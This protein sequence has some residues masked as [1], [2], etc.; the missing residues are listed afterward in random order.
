MRISA[1]T[2][3]GHHG[4]PD[5]SI[6]SLAPGLNVFYGPAGTGKTALADLVSHAL[7]GRTPKWGLH[8]D[9]VVLPEGQV[10]VET[11]GTRYRLRRYRNGTTDGRLTV[12]SLDGTQVHSEAVREL[13]HGLSPS[14]A[15][16]LY[17]MS[18]R[19]PPGLEAMLS[20]DFVRR[21]LAVERGQSN[22]RSA[23][24]AELLARREALAHDL[25]SRISDGRRASRTL[26]D[27]WGDLDRQ[28]HQ[29]EQ[30]IAKAR[31]QLRA[32][33]TAL[34]ET[35][36]RLRY[37]RLETSIDQLWLGQRSDCESLVAELDV[38]IAHWR[39]LLTDLSERQTRMR[40]QIAQI[41]PGDAAT[42]V[43]D[44][45]AWLSVARQLTTDL[46]GEVSRLARASTSRE[47]V[48][49]DA[50]PRLRPIVETLN[51][52]LN[53]LAALVD[54]HERAAEAGDLAREVEH[55]DRTEV[56]VRRQLDH[57]LDRRER[58]VRSGRPGLVSTSD[59]EVSDDSYITAADAELLEVRRSELEHQRY[60]LCGQIADLELDLAALCRQRDTI[61]RQ[62]ATLLSAGEID[63]LQ[64]ELASVERQLATLTTL[65]PDRFA[66]TEGIAT[67]LNRVSD[68]LAQLTG[69][70]LI[71]AELSVDGSAAHVVNRAGERLPWSVLAPARKDQ[72]Y[73]SLCLAL[74]SACEG[75]GVR[76]PLVLDEPFLRLDQ[77]DTAALAAVLDE[78][79]RCGS[80]ALVFTSQRAVAQRFNALGMHVHDMRDLRS[81]LSAA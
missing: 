31:D 46:E 49:G 55:L 80:Q 42:T 3:D 13:L 68:F 8:A 21:L 30:E 40:S 75:Q 26:R 5:L 16:R 43:A 69:G 4:R 63:Q 81:G 38:Q 79:A 27:Q 33:D 39:D 70:E 1:I 73:L 47:C 51:R 65:P 10:V 67:G 78:L 36:A 52:Q 61:D 57:L 25:E 11:T 66:A 72:L 77:H 59:D 18:F 20:T 54:R 32:V 48:C 64:Q 62:R 14:L 44:G 37:R 71:R 17:A 29:R 15:A 2:L 28:I 58:L 12:A 34:A 24:T 9:Q 6:D 7:Y 45:R 53:V 23:K 19:E 76:L 22:P 56:E 41:A 35:D 74:V 60:G 50:H